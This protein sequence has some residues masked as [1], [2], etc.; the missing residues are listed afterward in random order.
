MIGTTLLNRYQI[1]SQLGQ[2]GMGTV[3]RAHDSLLNRNVAI[4]ML[5]AQG[6]GTEGR[7]RM[8]AEAQAAAKLNHPNI[9][10]VF[11]AG[12]VDSTPF[13]VM[14]L[15]SG[16]TLRDAPALSLEDVIKTAS[17]ICDAL[18]HAHTNGI[19][20]RDLKLENIF[21]T[22]TGKIKLVDFGLA[23][24]TEAPHITQE[25]AIVGT[26][27]YIAPELIQGQPASA[28]SD[29]YAF[30]VMLYELVTGRVPFTGDNL[31]TIISQHLHVTPVP[32]STYNANISPAL[33]LLIL[34]LLAKQPSDRP[35]S[36]VDARDALD[37]IS[38]Q[39]ANTTPSAPTRL[40]QI[41][42][43]SFIGREREF[44]EANAQW[45]KAIG[46]Q[47]SVLLIS[48]EP[49]IG[50]TRLAR[51]LISLA[52]LSRGLTLVGE[53]YAEGGMPY[54]PIARI[55]QQAFDSDSLHQTLNLPAGTIADL[56]TIA[57]GLRSVF[58]DVPPNPP[59]DPQAEQQR[60]YES[61]VRFASAL[62]ARS[63]VLWLVDDAHWA[64]S[65]S[66]G[67]IR[68]LARR[69]RQMPILIVLT[70]R[71]VELSEARALNEVLADLNRERLA[72][73]VKLVRFS[74]EQTSSLLK[75]MFA[76]EITPDFLEG[77]FRETE[78]NPFFVEEVC[79]ALIEDG[80][81]YRENGRWQ[82]PGMDAIHVP[83]GVR[84]AIE[85]RLERL[86]ASAQEALRMAA[87][88]GR[89]FD[90][91]TLLKAG[92]Q[93]EDALID[94]LEAAQRAQLIVEF[95]RSGRVVFSFM[96]A[97]IPSAVRDSISALRVQRMYRKAAA[98]LE[99]VHPDD[100]EI[101]A[102]HFA[103]GG[104]EEPARRYYR[105]AADRAMSGGAL[106]D[107]E[108]FYR[109]ALDLA[110]EPLERADLMEQLGLTLVSMGLLDAAQQLCR[111]AIPLYLN[112]HDY[113]AVGRLYTT[114]SWT[115]WHSGDLPAGLACS[116]EGVAILDDK[117][118]S[119]GKAALYHELARQYYFNGKLRESRP[120]AQRALKMAEQFGNVGLQV[121][122]LVTRAL[123]EPIEEQFVTLSQALKIGRGAETKDQDF[124]L[125]IG[126]SR[127]FN[128]YAEILTGFGQIRAS[129]PLLQEMIEYNCGTGVGEAWGYVMLAYRQVELGEFSAAESS[130]AQARPLYEFGGKSQLHDLLV[131]NETYIDCC[132]GNSAA[133]GRVIEF[134]ERYQKDGDAQGVLR[135]GD[136]LL[137]HFILAGDTDRALGFVD[138]LQPFIL[139]D[140][141]SHWANFT[142]YAQFC[143][144]H[145]MRGQMDLARE[146]WTRV[147]QLAV[148][149]SNLSAQASLARAEA[150]IACAE[151][152]WDD[153]SAAFERFAQLQEKMERR[154]HHANALCEW[155]RMIAHHDQVRATALIDQAF[156]ILSELDVPVYAQT[157]LELKSELAKGQ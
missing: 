156:K 42:R 146:A 79:K 117:T 104:E 147:R 14:E 58:P 67:L 76:E 69:T 139:D 63:P 131:E 81:I 16:A 9:V 37:R 5:S 102:H 93:T 152:R 154:W 121:N 109:I 153:G 110:T 71:E 73:R 25:G 19:I 149:E 91:E 62:A 40:E 7:A 112:A 120:Y 38:A 59:L 114:L 143:A 83:Q 136:A 74:R 26:F 124:N 140:G 53:C 11:D 137:N 108:K 65:G 151:Q 145:V 48:G 142:F 24:S 29:L 6:L 68:H 39:T 52:G 80:K 141:V 129:I 144:V 60:L 118:D 96:H 49:G 51:E 107:A 115:F 66:L 41:V 70:Y 123:T 90:F 15:I 155:A 101:L 100:Y 12:E 130:L 17:Q 31:M 34:R 10:T 86:P 94:S 126:T 8:I 148:N 27:A 43:G 133:I 46:G 3:Y 45:Q 135:A 99:A 138:K 95:N 111:E 55:L 64:D 85:S 113:D 28:Q 33:E 157:V 13:V 18:D 78:G 32:P 36:A 47:G 87:V 134:F 57:P 72:E 97:L 4:K 2:G 82:R 56:I 88:I 1:E 128:N 127:A 21:L 103:Q 92:D 84:V 89:E 116:L 106:S 119:N 122:S 23:R 105:L 30:G 150:Y 54:A 20:H 44:S 61:V 132:R 75:A 77:I 35:A 98:A 50:K 22:Q 125:V